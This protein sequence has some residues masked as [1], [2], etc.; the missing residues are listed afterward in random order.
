MLP[1]ASDISGHEIEG[2]ASTAPLTGLTLSAR[3]WQASRASATSFRPR[4]GA[5]MSHLSALLGC[6]EKEMRVGAVDMDVCDDVMWL[7]EH[8]VDRSDRNAVVRALRRV[9]GDQFH[10]LIENENCLAAVM[11]PGWK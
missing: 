6:S 9:C 4:N 2:R 5:S 1:Y 11:D 8:G 10:P 3:Q 7:E